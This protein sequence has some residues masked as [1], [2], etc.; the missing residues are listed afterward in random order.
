VPYKGGGPAVTALLGAEVNYTLSNFPAVRAHVQS[1]RLKI[2]ASCG[3]RRTALA[4]QAPTFVESGMT[5]FQ[6]V[7]WYG[8]HYPARTPDAIVSQVNAEVRRALSDRAIAEGLLLQGA[9]AAPS[10]PEAVTH[11]MRE[12][13]ARWSKVIQTQKLTF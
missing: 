7:T 10:T 8:F 3:A 12:E 13:S 5:D 2:I 4:P 6:Y 9:E 11:M 1:G